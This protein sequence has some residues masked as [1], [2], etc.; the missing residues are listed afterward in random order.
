M[1]SLC[2]LFGALAVL[3]MSLI[4]SSALGAERQ[5][6]LELVLNGR[7][8]GRVGEFI[9]HDGALYARPSELRGLGF[10]VSPSTGEDLVALSSLPNIHAQVNEA[11]QTLV[12]VASEAALR[13]TEIGGRP[14]SGSAPLTVSKLGAVLNYDVIGTSTGGQTSGG[15]LLDA[16]VFG[17]YGVLQ[18]DGLVSLP[19]GPGQKAF[20]RLDTTYTF[21]EP[22][23][24]R[25]WRVG[26]VTTGALAWSRAVRLGGIQVTSDFSLRPDLVTYPLPVISSSAAVPSTVDVLVNGIRQYSEPVQAGPFVARTLPVV[27]GAGEVVVAVQDGL[28]RQTLLTLPFYAS[29]A[30]L[31]PGLASYSVELGTVRRNYGLATDGYS[32]WA[33]SGSLRYGLLD[34]LTLETHEEATQ[35]LTLGGVGAALRVGTIGILNAAVS[36]SLGRGTALLPAGSA[37]GGG[38]VSLG[39]QRVSR[40]FSLS[41]SGSKR[42][43]GYRDIA[44]VNGAPAPNTTLNASIGHQL[45]KYG[46]AGLAYIYQTTKSSVFGS[47]PIGLHARHLNGSTTKLITANYSVPVAK[48]FTLYATGFEDLHQAHSYGLGIGVSFLFGRSTSVSAG[49]SLDS[50]RA[51]TFASADKPALKQG[52]FGYQLQDTEGAAPQRLAQGE[53]LS[54]W[55]SVT[56]GISQSPGKVAGRVEFQGALAWIDS[57]LFASD[58]IYDSFAIVR[59]GNVANVPV[60][61]ENRLL[62]TT[63]SGGKLLVPTLVSYQDNK[64]AVDATRLPADVEVGQTN[65]LVRPA[66]RSGVVVNFQ[67]NVVK[68]ALLKLRDRHGQPIPL[69]SIARVAGAPDRPVGYDGEAYVTGLVAANRLD[70]S[71]GWR[72]LHRAVR[73]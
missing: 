68:A 50:G 11:K 27:T 39:F 33:M 2:L 48:R 34:W 62:G 55:G 38:F 52:D 64:L 69:G 10:V 5:L 6:L 54:R 57:S 73:L 61:Y 41:V 20:A 8:T 47:D 16:R 4:A 37:A 7:P 12:V 30:L 22:A 66:D 56:A 29:T 31:K 46:N 25:R 26:D 32:G 40:G 21:S 13:P 42:S 15:A 14:S 44:A 28:G 60:M 18:A 3:T 24:A 72:P 1:R 35:A 45:G 70:R 9:D 49:A 36:G 23:N 19:P 53:F 43:D 17:P 71:A 51:S 58:H 59:T 63:D 65:I 67:V